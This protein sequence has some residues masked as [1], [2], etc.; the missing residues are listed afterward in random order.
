MSCVVVPGETL[1]VVIIVLLALR[2][3]TS[4]GFAM[5]WTVVEPSRPRYSAVTVMS[6]PDVGV[7]RTLPSISPSEA[8]SS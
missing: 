6:P 3:A 1:R 8:D 5:A 4:V 7:V 2:M